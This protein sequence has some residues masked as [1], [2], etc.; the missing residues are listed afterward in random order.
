MRVLVLNGPN[1]DRLGLRQP[2]V[3]GSETLDD[4]DNLVTA[5]GDTLGIEIETMQSNREGALIDRINQSDHDGIIINPGALAHTSRALADALGSVPIPAVEVHISNIRER[6]P[7]RAISV[8][9]EACVRSIYGRGTK[10][11]L[12]ALRHLKNRAAAPWATVRYGPHP[13]QVGDLRR[14]EGG[15]V[16]L[17]HGGFWRQ[18]WERDTMETLAVHL[19]G[20]GYHTWNIEY[21]R[22]GAG[23]GWPGSAH[24][25]LT[26]LDFT[27]Q[28]DLGVDRPI[29][30]VGHSAGGHLAM[31]AVSRTRWVVGRLVALAPVVDLPRHAASGLFGADEAQA[32]LDSGGPS[33]VDPGVVPTTLLHGTGDVLVPVDHSRTL[34]GIDGVELLTADTGHFELLDPATGWSQDLTDRLAPNP[35][36]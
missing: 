35:R 4:L 23:G 36:R 18:E 33:R 8:V 15:L 28:L 31:W 9:A 3:Y 32:L 6:E 14:G 34:E 27:P 24:D 12:D 2:E 20:K 1:L 17:V 10:G 5:A 13:E 21:R 11:Y 25:V 26:A 16:V 19:V 30:V 29:S 22:L 7:W